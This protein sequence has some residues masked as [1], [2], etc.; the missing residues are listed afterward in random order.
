MNE[1]SIVLWFV[2]MIAVVTTAAIIAICF[3]ALSPL[4]QRSRNRL[5]RLIRENRLIEKRQRERSRHERKLSQTR[6][7]SIID[8][9]QD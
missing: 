7:E 9:L 1:T 6:W 2:L 5:K 8:R 4:E 3:P